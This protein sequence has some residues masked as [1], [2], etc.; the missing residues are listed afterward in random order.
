MSEEIKKYIDT[1]PESIQIKL[2]EM[3][4]IIKEVVPK[5]VI[6]KI[7]W[8]MPTFYLGENLV[9]FAAFKNH[10]GLFPGGEVLEKFSNKLSG[11]KYSKGGVQFNYD[12]PLP[13]DLIQEIVKDRVESIKWNLKMK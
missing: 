7:S 11:L 6:E 10:I 2:K 5:E 1:F 3:Y 12:K 9:H 13:K 4:E 8:K